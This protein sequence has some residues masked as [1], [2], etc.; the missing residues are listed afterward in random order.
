VHELGIVRIDGNHYDDE[1]KAK[2]G[3]L[4]TRG[5]RSHWESKNHPNS[6]VTFDFTGTGRRLNLWKYEIQTWNSD[7]GHLN[8]WVVEVSGDGRTWE[9]L[10]RRASVTQLNRPSS[11]CCFKCRPHDST[12][13][14]LRITQTGKNSSGMDILNLTRVEFYGELQ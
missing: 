4:V 14:Y 5:W 2:I 9:E 1:E 6:W 13:S 11:R 12:Y 8:Q 10:D 3:G 7:V